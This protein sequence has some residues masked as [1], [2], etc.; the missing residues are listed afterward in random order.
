MLSCTRQIYLS[1]FSQILYLVL[2]EYFPEP[3]DVII[4]VNSCMPLCLGPT[5]FKA[6]SGILIN[7][8]YKFVKA[9]IPHTPPPPL[10]QNL[11]CDSSTYKNTFGHHLRSFIP[12]CHVRVVD[13]HQIWHSYLLV[14]RLST[15]CAVHA[16]PP[17]ATA[18][19][20]QGIM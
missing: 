15:A 2:W 17:P 1:I 18:Y 13:T 5:P 20:Y 8:G 7:I 19:V 10:C 6:H 9:C 11:F 14:F 16:P 12:H 3:S 4:T